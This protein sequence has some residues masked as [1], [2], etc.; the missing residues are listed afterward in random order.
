[1]A[2]KVHPRHFSYK[3]PTFG[4]IKNPRPDSAWKK[5]V[6]YLWWEY[7]L[8][9]EKYLKTCELK[10]K[11]GLVDLYKDFGDIRNMSF[12]EWWTE[13]G[14]GYFLFSEPSVDEIVRILDEGDA[15]PNKQVGICILLP[16]NLPKKHLKIKIDKLLSKHHSG[17]AGIQHSRNS[18]AKYRVSTRPYLNTLEKILKIY[19]IKKQNPSLKLWEIGN[20]CPNYLKAHKIKAGDTDAVMRDKKNVLSA[21]VKRHLNQVNL[22]I[23]KV[24]KGVFP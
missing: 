11:A 8:R 15:I 23:E 10:G 14:R 3:H 12:K 20:E 6:Y 24:E 21:S 16:L 13:N 1:M 2:K 7:L 4:T 18:F 5:T 22:L 9:S 19:D 17:K